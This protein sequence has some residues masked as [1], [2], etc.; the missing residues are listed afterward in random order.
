MKTTLAALTTIVALAACGGKKSG[1]KPDARVPDAAPPPDAGFVAS[2]TFWVPFAV[3]P[4]ATGGVDGVYVVPSSSPT[5]TPVL[6][7]PSTT[8]PFAVATGVAYTA[9]GYIPQTAMYVATTNGDNFL[10]SIA[11]DNVSATPVAVQASDVQIPRLTET[12]AGIGS[13]PG[14]PGCDGFGGLAYQANLADPTSLFVLF[15]MPAN[16]GDACSA[17]TDVF[18]LFRYAGGNPVTLGNVEIGEPTYSASGELAGWLSIDNGGDLSLWQFDSATY[19]VKQSPTALAT[20]L[21]GAQSLPIAASTDRSE[22]IF[23]AK[24]IAGN[25]HLYGA[26]AS[27]KL[28]MKLDLPAGQTFSPFLN[29]GGIIQD[30]NQLCVV[31]SSTTDDFVYCAPFDAS[32]TTPVTPTQVLDVT[33]STTGTIALVGLLDSGATLVYET[34]LGS[35]ETIN[36]VTNPGGAITSLGATPVSSFNVFVDTSGAYVYGAA[37]D[38]NQNLSTWVATLASGLPA[39]TALGEGSAT[40]L[41]GGSTLL[42]SDCGPVSSATEVRSTLVLRESNVVPAQTGGETFDV[43]DTPTTSDVSLVVGSGGSAFALPSGY[44]VNSEAAMQCTTPSGP[45]IS[46]FGYTPSGS[47]SGAQAAILALDQGVMTPV[48]I[49]SA[50]A[51]TTDV[52]VW[53]LQPE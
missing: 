27:N 15:A 39:L 35:A 9:H 50:S 53:G 2:T 21:D 5:T 25:S 16:V 48:T 47:G 14:L 11:L 49:P 37:R 41:F 30:G 28:A 43:I 34:I 19:T 36:T 23:E 7:G 8:F 10:Y 31:A 33:T 52:F 1:N 32:A 40:Y 18:K 17:G 26:S 3:Q 38:I 45:D 44:T 20:G 4:I 42:S 29:S 22:V 12:R 6:V 46:V 13:Y 24:D 51:A